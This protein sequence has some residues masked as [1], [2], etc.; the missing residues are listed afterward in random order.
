MA[1]ESMHLQS[2]VELRQSNI[3]SFQ[4]APPLANQEIGGQLVTNPPYELRLKTGNVD[5]L[6][7]EIGDALKNNCKGY[8]A[9]LFSANREALKKV[10]LRTSRK[11]P[12][13]NGPL[14]AR[15]QRYD[16]Y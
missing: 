6:Y 11:I 4:P 3:Q 15:L 7:K 16:M 9:W 10:G 12:L 5:Q 1:L 14:E 8:Q 2:F 13:M